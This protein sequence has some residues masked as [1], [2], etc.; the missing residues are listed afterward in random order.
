[1][2]YLASRKGAF[3]LEIGTLSN[4]YCLTIRLQKWSH[5]TSEGWWLMSYIAK[6]TPLLAVCYS[7]NYIIYKFIFYFINIYYLYFDDVLV[8]HII[9]Y[10]NKIR[11]II[12]NSNYQLTFSFSRKVMQVFDGQ[13]KTHCLSI[14]L[15]G[16]V[17]CY[18]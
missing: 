17:W 6:Y 4:W 1:M 11:N 9:I 2:E 8:I 3:V 10:F 16:F 12:K 14:L 18:V 15:I 13:R 5:I 7:F